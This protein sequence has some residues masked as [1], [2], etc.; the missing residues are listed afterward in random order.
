MQPA[1]KVTAQ[2]QFGGKYK[3]STLG[4]IKFQ[5]YWLPIL[6][7]FLWAYF[8]PLVLGG[9]QGNAGGVSG[10]GTASLSSGVG[11]LSSVGASVTGA[12]IVGIGAKSV[13]G[14]NS[15]MTSGS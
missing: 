5:L 1:K 15:G 3:D 12:G 11:G 9:L 2:K 6:S 13:V 10:G 8:D 14:S 4:I 7:W